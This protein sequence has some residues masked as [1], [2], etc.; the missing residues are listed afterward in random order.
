MPR[1][2]HRLWALVPASVAAF[3]LFSVTAKAATP[4]ENYGRYCAQ[5]HGAEG[6][7]DGINATEEMPV[8]PRNHTDAGEMGKLTAEDVYFA[9]KDGGKS[10]GKSALMPNWGGTLKDEEIKSLVEHLNKLCGCTY[11]AK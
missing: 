3:S 5:C 9:I 8:S 1:K 2:Y 6:K 7:G 11:K 10:V 4:E